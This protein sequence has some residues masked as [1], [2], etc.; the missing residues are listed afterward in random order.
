M[1]NS[2]SLTQEFAWSLATSLMV[3]VILFQADDRY[4][5]MPSAE[6]DGAPEAVREQSRRLS[7]C[8]TH[9]L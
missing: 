8:R 4:G 1:S 5:A 2:L 3:A 6:F 7:L 9:R